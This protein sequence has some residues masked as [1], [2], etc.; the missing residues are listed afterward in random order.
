MR[1]LFLLIHKIEAVVLATSVIAMALITIANVFARNLLDRNLAA[2]EELNE[3]LIVVVC[4]VGIGYAASEGRHIRMTA[5][6]DQ[7]GRRARKAVT[8]LICAVTAALLFGLAAYALTYVRGIQRVSPVLGLPL[9]TVYLVVPLGLALGGLQYVL[10]L[11][12]NL[13]HP[14]VYLSFD[15]VDRYDAAPETDDTADGGS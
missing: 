15:R 13:T 3:F 14:E 1:R 5:L 8:I 10:T 11:V 4:F 7:L 9:S 12:R 6:Y 2:A